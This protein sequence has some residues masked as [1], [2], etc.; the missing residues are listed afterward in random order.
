MRLSADRE[1][2]NVQKLQE[3]GKRHACRLGHL[4]EKFSSFHQLMTMLVMKK[5]ENK[6]IDGCHLQD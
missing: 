4:E 6:K 1:N 3:I 5:F 2:G